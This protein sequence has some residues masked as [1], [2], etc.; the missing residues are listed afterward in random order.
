MD[1]LLQQLVNGLSLGGIYA[2]IA[3]GYTM[4]YG[5]IELINF[6]HG[7]V[8]TLG[9]FFSLGIL[10]LL[11]V[12]G[13]V[14]GPMLILVVA[15]TIFGAMI[16]CGLTGVIIERLA[17]RRLRNAPKLA[18]LITAIGMSFILENVMLY[19]RGPSPV[20]FPQVMPNPQF[21]LGGVSIQAKQ[22]IV[23]LLAIVLMIVL[24]TFIYNTRLGKAMRATAQDRDAAQ[25]M[26]ININTTIALTFLIGSALAG[27]AGFVSGVY[28]G[29]TWFF[30][31]FAAGLKAFTA[32]VLGGIGNLAGAML[33][34]FVIGLVE[35]LTTQFISDQWS[36]IAVFS[37]LVLVLIFR[38][39]GIL[40]ESLPNKV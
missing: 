33:G 36:N 34:G 40:G 15:V 35:A 30:N 14:T 26:G 21:A 12:T 6:A 11:G 17:Y 24:Q 9:T 37:V 5:I 28:Y 29:S 31:G 22:I 18:P 25:L 32:A 8:Y 39:S 19:W 27:A 16:L 23:V 7:D 1:L 3:L 13:I 10:T 4:V 2:L 38:P 20:P